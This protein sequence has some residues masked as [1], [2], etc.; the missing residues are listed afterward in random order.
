MQRRPGFLSK[1]F[2]SNAVSAFV[3]YHGSSRHCNDP[4]AV[5]LMMDD[6]DHPFGDDVD[7]HRHNNLDE[8]HCGHHHHIFDDDDDLTNTYYRF[9]SP[10]NHDHP[11]NNP[12][13]AFCYD[14]IHPGSALYQQPS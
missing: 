1:T 3:A 6:H 13:L 5:D 12:V 8:I 9:L 4:D 14:H 11:S 7:D 2:L 10:L